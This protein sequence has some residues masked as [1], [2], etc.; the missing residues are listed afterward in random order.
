MQNQ[1]D[2]VAGLLLTLGGLGF[3]GY[4]FL[5]LSLGTLQR[6]GPGLFPLI[7]G[8][9]ITVFGLIVVAGSLN[10]PERQEPFNIRPFVFVVVG[11]VLFALTIRPFGLIPAS[12]LLVVTV[13]ASEGT[14][15]YRVLILAGVLAMVAALIFVAGLQVP[16]PLARW[17]F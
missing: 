17:P 11:F 12:F 5:N 8:T 15:T 9:L 13:S 1:R 6:M 2:L 10:A 4:A 14:M 3:A 7:V 16:V